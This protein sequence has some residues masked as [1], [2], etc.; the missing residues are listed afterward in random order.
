MSIDSSPPP[1]SSE[2]PEPSPVNVE[3]GIGSWDED[4]E[5]PEKSRGGCIV[6]LLA[7]IILWSVVALE[8]TGVIN[9]I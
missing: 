2:S 5:G 3:V 1:S 4:D 9:V 6:I 8:L 7:L